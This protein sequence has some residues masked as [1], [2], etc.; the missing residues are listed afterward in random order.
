V[1]PASFYTRRG[2]GYKRFTKV[3]PNPLDNRIVL[4]EKYPVFNIYDK[5]LENYPLVIEID[6]KSLNEDVVQE[7]NGVFFADETIYLNS[8]TTKI[9]FRNEQEMRSTLSKAEPSIETKM[10][11][12]Y[13]NCFSVKSKEIESF[14]WKTI[15]IE[16]SKEDISKYISKDRKINKLK[17]LLYAYLLAANKSVSSDVG[18]LKK[19][20]RNLQNILSAIITSPDGR[21]DDRQNSELQYLNKAINDKFQTVYLAPI[22][23]GKSKEYKCNFGEILR[24]ENLFDYWLSRSIFSK[25]QIAEF[26]IPKKDKDKA[27]E[28]YIHDVENKISDLENSQKSKIDVSKLPEL[29]S[30]K[31]NP[32]PDQKPFLAKLFNEY[33]EEAYNSEEFIKSRYEFA[34]S[35]GKI[36]KDELQD[37]WDDSLWQQYINTLLKN[38]NE[39]SAFDIKS[40]NNLTLESFAAFCQ[41]G[42]SDIDKLEDYL[43]SNEIGDF[44]IAFSLWGIVF[45][46][47]GMPKT[48]T[49]DLF[50]SDD[51]DYISEVYKYIF[52]QVHGIELEEKFITKK[53]TED[54][55]PPTIKIKP[56]DLDAQDIIS[57]LNDCKLK[58]EQLD[59]IQEIY[60]NNRSVINDKFFTNVKIIKGIGEKTLEKIKN[61]LRYESSSLQKSIP[62][63]KIPF[64]EIRPKPGTEFYKDQNALSYLEKLLPR[65]RK[66]IKQFKD[67]LDWFQDEY[68]KGTSSQYYSKAPRDNSSIIESFKRYIEKKKYVNQLDIAN[69]ISRLKELYLP[70]E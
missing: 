39:H 49:N 52:K 8:F 6:T 68:K 46:F 43:V 57:R 5:E 7:Q 37:K 40:A 15:E 64:E 69:I 60:K 50:L 3:E 9:Y 22:L 65:D 21:A 36:F 63:E 17:G 45:G 38:L 56:N 16:D 11:S 30:R 42:E 41:K 48:L 61:V 18:F 47:A 10:V 23:E 32:I 2:F 44:R 70:N 31:I 53:Q 1:S 66:I 26:H 13:K 12:L 25:Y 51:S 67:D 4:Y 55:P 19:Y 34:K 33:L 54:T 20:L 14:D 35:G 62:Q 58:P 29:Q 24:K 28:K 27:F 59:H